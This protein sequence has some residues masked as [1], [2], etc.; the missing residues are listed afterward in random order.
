[1]SARRAF[2]YGVAVVVTL[3]E[4]HMLPPALHLGFYSTIPLAVVC[5]WANGAVAA[6]TA[7]KMDA[8]Y[9]AVVQFSPV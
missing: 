1:M 5:G 9:S 7:R 6:N 3:V 2:L 8:Y 4:I